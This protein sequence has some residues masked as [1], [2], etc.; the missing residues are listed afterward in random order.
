MH[1]VGDTKTCA[2]N[3]SCV[4]SACGYKLAG[5]IDLS[6]SGAADPLGTPT[7]TDVRTGFMIFWS[8]VPYAMFFML[9]AAFLY[10]GDTSSL[11]LIALMGLLVICNEGL[12]KHSINQKRP[13]GSCL[14][15]KSYGMPSGHAATSIGMMTS[16]L[17]ETWVDRSANLDSPSRIVFSFRNKCICTLALLFLLL[18]VPF[19]RV[20]H[21]HY[22][23]QVLVGSRGDRFGRVVVY[24]HV[25]ICTPRLGT[26]VE[27][28]ISRCFLLRNTYRTAGVQWTPEW[29]RCKCREKLTS[30]REDG[31]DYGSGVDQPSA[32][33]SGVEMSV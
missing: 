30:G 14:Y 2:A 18:P 13:P 4:K 29:A 32:K 6:V 26:W 8:I 10:A 12:L 25:Q 9:F 15:F 33:A 3:V 20:V 11:S 28:R 23:S 24:L 31:G 27:L 22:I 19:S 7:P 16:M 1:G 21:D 17:L 5:G